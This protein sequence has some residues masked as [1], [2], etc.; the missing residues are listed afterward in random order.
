MVWR[1]DERVGRSI[2]GDAVAEVADVVVGSMEGFTEGAH[3][4]IQRRRRVLSSLRPWSDPRTHLSELVWPFSQ[5]LNESMRRHDG[6]AHQA[7]GAIPQA[8]EG[9]A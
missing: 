1:C 8:A 9:N 2:P 6:N 3:G 5:V 4:D 7:P